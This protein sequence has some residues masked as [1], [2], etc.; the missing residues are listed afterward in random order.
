[1]PGRKSRR[2]PVAQRAEQIAREVE[3]LEAEYEKKTRRQFKTDEGFENWRAKNREKLAELNEELSILRLLARRDH[4]DRRRQPHKDQHP[5]TLLLRLTH[6]QG[7]AGE[8][9][10]GRRG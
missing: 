10:R 8:T 9:P 4:I 7:R 5:D 6:H 1:V 2:P 3:K